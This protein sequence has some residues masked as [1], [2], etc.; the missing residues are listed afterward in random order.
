MTVFTAAAAAALPQSNHLPNTDRYSFLTEAQFELKRVGKNAPALLCKILKV[1]RSKEDTIVFYNGDGS[2]I[3][4]DEFPTD[5]DTFDKMFFTFTKREILYCR[6]EIRSARKSFHEIKLDA[7]H[8]LEPY[9][10]WLRRSPGPIDRLPLTA[11]GFWIN[12]HPIFANPHAWLD[13]IKI[14]VEDNYPSRA[15]AKAKNLPATYK[16]MNDV[17]ISRGRVSGKYLP[18]ETQESNDIEADVLMMYSNSE[19]YSTAMTLVTQVSRFANPTSDSAPIFI[20]I[21]LKKADPTK[22][23]HYLAKHN[24]FMRNHRNIAVV[25][26]SPELM[27]HQRDGSSLW[28]HIRSQPGVF[29]CDPCSATSTIGKWNI[30]SDV[31]YNSDIKNWL[32]KILDEWHTA[33]PA[34]F[35]TFQ[36]FPEPEILSKDRRP[37]TPSVSSG[38]TNASPIES[39]LKTLVQALPTPTIPPHVPRQNWKSTVPIER[40]EYS[41]DLDAFPALPT[42]PKTAHQPREP[43]PPTGP[44]TTNTAPTTNT[45]LPSGAPASV[46]AIT[47]DIISTT[48]KNQF[49]AL[50]ETTQAQ[51]KELQDRMEALDQQLAE[52]HTRIDTISERLA[53][54]VID[55]LTA[56][57]GI[58]TKHERMLSDQIL[59]TNKI[60]DTL[61]K[62]ANSM[63]KITEVT[64]SLTADD[65]PIRKKRRGSSVSSEG[66]SSDS[67]DTTT[68]LGDSIQQE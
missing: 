27:D 47:E 62:L 23:G 44:T 9:K 1:L 35:P 40:I 7:W 26:V 66:D 21:E 2:P 16:P 56:P 8:I 34:T 28:K 57:D 65:S 50:N 4:V 39:Y 30:S 42:N 6:F 10:I 22:F 51:Q 19:E 17:Y 48:V 54:Q 18:A 46:S 41:F 67:S 49:T 29:R 53:T 59:T 5:K 58:L 24:N 11:M 20:P 61:T 15:E 33:A 14:S 64:D 52:I 60:M 43:A 25:G 32:S 12:V 31:N 55:T 63:H 38:L 3:N 36:T 68:V 45:T 37:R 13:E